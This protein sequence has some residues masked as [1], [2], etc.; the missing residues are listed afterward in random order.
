M[1]LRPPRPN[2]ISA[3]DDSELADAQPR[4]PSASARRGSARASR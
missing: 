4:A 2:Q 1:Q 3:L